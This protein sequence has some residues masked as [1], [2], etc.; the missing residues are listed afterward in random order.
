MPGGDLWRLLLTLLI[1]RGPEGKVGWRW[2]LRRPGWLAAR[3]AQNARVEVVNPADAI[4]PDLT[5]VKVDGETY[6]WPKDT[7]LDDLL[8]IVC[9][10]VRPDHPHQ[11]LWGGT[12]IRPRDVVLDVG[13]CEGGFA[14]IAAAKGAQVVAVEPSQ[15]MQRL[16]RRLFEIRGL[17]EPQIVGCALGAQRGTAA[18]VEEA[19]HPAYASLSNA[20]AGAA[21]TSVDVVPLDQLVED[22]KLPRVDFIK[23]D[24]EGF[25]LDIVKSGHNTIQRFHPRLAVCTYH[26]DDHFV[27]LHDYLT[28]LGYRVRGKG[29]MHVPGKYRVLMLHAW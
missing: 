10:L 28:E 19:D 6:V 22:L 23:C 2:V 17:P 21:V 20:P 15:K 24:A 12:Q 25:D 29:F 1:R 18:L 14:A 3:F 7:P 4:E 9:E 11:Y 13:S 5:V 26:A 27:R 8:V 16:I